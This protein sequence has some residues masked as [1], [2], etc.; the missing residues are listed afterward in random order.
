MKIPCVSCQSMFLLD[1]NLV[2][3]TGSLVRCSKCKYI[4]MVYP[5]SYDDKPITRDTNIDQSILFD[6]FNVERKNLAKD[7]LDQTQEV[8]DSHKVDEIASV[9]DFEQE[10]D[11]MPEDVDPAYADLPDLSDYED[12]IDWDES[13]D[14]E[15]LCD[16]EKQF[17]NNTQDLD[18]N[19]N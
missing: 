7:V 15:D 4:F 13:P 12:M 17:Y 10:E 2:K 16:G 1:S 3:S 8:I 5:P 14:A 18:L 11:Q 19:D 6:L 9:N